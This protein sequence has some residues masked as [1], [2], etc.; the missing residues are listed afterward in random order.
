MAEDEPVWER[1]LA[2]K[3]SPDQQGSSQLQPGVLDGRD[4]NLTAGSI[5]LRGDGRTAELMSK[6]TLESAADLLSDKASRELIRRNRYVEYI[7]LVLRCTVANQSGRAK[8]TEIAVKC[9]EVRQ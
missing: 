5:A 6:M 1:F 2:S 3:L 4:M 8:K 7:R 9:I